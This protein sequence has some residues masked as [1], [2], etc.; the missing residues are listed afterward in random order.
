MNVELEEYAQRVS[1]QDEDNYLGIL[2]WYTISECKVDHADVV[3]F[4]TQNGLSSLLPPHPADVDVFRRVTTKC[5]RTKVTDPNKP[6]VM[7]NYI[8]RSVDERD[9]VTVT[10]QIVEEVVDKTGKRLSYHP[11]HFLEFNRQQSSIRTGPIDPVVGQNRL[12]DVI[13][14]DMVHEIKSEFYS[15]QGKLNSYAIRELVRRMVNNLG[16]TIVRPG[17]GVYFVQSKHKTTVEALE[18][19][20]ASLPGSNAFHSLPLVDDRKQREMVRTAYEAETTGAI[21]ELLGEISEI[22]RTGKQISS[23]KYANILTKYQDLM[24]NTNEYSDL[25]ET[26]LGETHSRLKLFQQ[27]I[28]NLRGNVK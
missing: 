23:D 8:V 14:A 24:A 17:G 21:D 12:C 28:I 1:Q 18:S 5:Q 13:S 16:S 19:F 15:W 2:C 9:P 27:S 25:L 26:T 10:R 20:V 4:L 3:Q 11:V 7:L 6:G 22:Q